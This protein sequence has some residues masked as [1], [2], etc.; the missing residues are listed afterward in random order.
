MSRER[1]LTLEQS[2]S[3]RSLPSE[4]EAATETTCDEP[5]TSPIPV[6]LCH[7]ERGRG[8]ETGLKLSPGRR[9]GTGKVF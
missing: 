1:D 3:V 2:K 4:E 5:A 9:E 8:R 7:S 6:P